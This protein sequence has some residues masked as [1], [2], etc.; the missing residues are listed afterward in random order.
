[1]RRS[2]LPFVCALFLLTVFPV[3]V[4]PGQAVITEFMARNGGTLD[5]EDGDSSDWIE[6]R[7][8][9]A[10][11]LNLAFWTLTDDASLP[12]KWTF[13]L[14]T[15][16]PGDHLVV[17]A[18]GKDR[19]SPGSELHTNFKLSADGE[20]LGL[21]APGGGVATEF[22]PAFP[23]QHIDVAYGL[24]GVT[25]V[26]VV[27]G[28][29]CEAFIPSN[30]SLGSS[31]QS[32]PVSGWLTGTTGVGYEQGTGYQSLIGLDV[33][34]SMYTNN[35]SAYIRVSFNVTDPSIFEGMTLRMKYDDG[36]A[37]FVNGT[38]IAS[39]NAPGTLAY[40]SPSTTNRPDTQAVI[41]EDHDAT[42]GLPALVVGAN[43]LAIQGLNASSSNVDF[44]IVPELVAGG[45][46]TQTGFLVEPTPGSVNTASVVDFV[47]DVTSTVPRGFKSSS[48]IVDLACAT[49][50]AVVRYTTDGSVPDE[51]SPI[52]SSSISVTGSMVLRGRGFLP[53]WGPSRTM[54]HTYVFPQDVFAQSAQIPG[55]PT[56]W[57]GT[58][59]N[60]LS[61]A[62]DYEMDPTVTTN[63][64]YAGRLQAALTNHPVVSLAMNADQWL[65]P[66]TGVYIS[67]TNDPAVPRESLTSVEYFEPVGNEGFHIDAGIRV[68][69]NNSTRRWGSKKLSLRLL[70]KGAYG[71]G[72]LDYPLFGIG[73]ENRFDTLTLDAYFAFTWNYAPYYA[74]QTT[75]LY[76]WQSSQYLRD[77][78]SAVM[79]ADM[80]SV[81]THGKW[82]HLFIN[83]VYWGLY[84]I[85]ERPD[86]DFMADYEG[87]DPDDWDVIRHNQNN[88]QSGNNAGW[89]SL[90]NLVNQSSG[91]YVQ[92]QAGY[93]AVKQILDVEN[94]CDYM[95]L[96]L[97]TGFSQDW[98]SS[99]WY[100][101]HD[102]VTPGA[103]WK[104]YS[105][106]AEHIIKD[107]NWDSTGVSTNGSPARLYH[108][109]RQ[110]E[111][112]KV[113]FGDRLH[114]FFFNGGPLY[115]NPQN[116]GWDPQNPQ[117]NR[118]SALYSQLADE[119]EDA[120]I[121]ESARWGDAFV[122][123][124]PPY[125]LN[126]HWTVERDRILN[127]YMPQ[128]AA[129]VLNQFRSRDL[130]PN[131]DAPV[132]AQ[133]GGAV[134]A[135]YA[136][137]MSGPSGATIWFSVDGTD[138]RLE[139]GATSS[140]ATAYSGPVMLASSVTVKARAYD[141]SEWSALNEAA[142]VIEAASV[143]E[144]LAK[145][146][147]GILDEVGEHEDWFELV[148]A[149]ASAMDLSGF[150]LTDDVAAPQKWA[151][152]SGTILLPG[153]TLLVWA[154]NE[155]T[156]G[157]YHATFRIDDAGEQIAIFQP[158]GVTLQ[159]VVTFG[160]QQPDV[161]TGRL[162]DGG[163]QLVTFPT[164]TPD[165]LNA[166]GACG[167]RRYDMLASEA[168]TIALDV[169]GSPGIGQTFT[170]RT[171]FGPP[172]SVTPLLVAS[173]PAMIPVPFTAVTLLVD[174]TFLELAQPTSDVF[175][176]TL[177]PVTLPSD[178][179]LVGLT[180]YLQSYA[181]QGAT[182]AASNAL[183]VRIC[184]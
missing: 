111:E 183:E 92:S 163:A 173:A 3:P 9:G 103:K 20:Y 22:A 179:A 139:G 57:G 84:N 118:P 181:I 49:P 35:S 94:L 155:P 21:Y 71:A 39:S 95:I 150:W 30:G 42:A 174:L 156:D 151:I 96:N 27:E 65:D 144:I 53:G 54:S 109:L 89:L 171:L 107:V 119:I 175:G 182:V 101:A 104:M 47:A 1:M 153:D 56:I 129:I 52:H 85:H 37:A 127:Q 86:E 19:A 160:P 106:D 25:S 154:D 5:D 41:F 141:G 148:N 63:P 10:A 72:K 105:W 31:W 176:T 177:V 87:G 134:P 128:R 108:R 137:T 28:A 158:D 80:G 132:F 124:G 133:H 126:D 51:T 121:L 135:G 167:V 50:G 14:W 68:S 138:P 43:V 45:Y 44:L 81:A 184:P 123:S 7:N 120:M 33:G 16:Q 168:S 93:D 59:S 64:A 91:T 40:N 29:G 100:S 15:L 131:L 6:V 136:L 110:N 24:E 147:N 161:S 172:Q 36:F 165:L 83:G 34:P 18:S 12:M 78:F 114:R 26:L 102:R 17:F 66:A 2:L 152:P 98:P 117:N 157:P 79:H 162:F 178:P 23:P 60:G 75:L 90:M 146:V 11:A 116:P 115:V 122:T 113:L 38:P 70:F 166:S 99:N 67:P 8:T 170:F 4:L 69:G 140:S 13:P 142:F 76:R 82:T 159:D 149:T 112:F 97:F 48:F 125:T 32:G 58:G 55:L 145:N 169:V 77:H 143:N 130:Y 88:V 180:F 73:A 62:A 46:G 61:I 164:P 74:T